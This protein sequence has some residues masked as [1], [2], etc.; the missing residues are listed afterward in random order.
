MTHI[1]FYFIFI[2]YL[3]YVVYTIAIH[4]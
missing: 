4:K 3:F 2:S 1:L